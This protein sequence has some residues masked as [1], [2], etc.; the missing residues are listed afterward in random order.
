MT[1]FHGAPATSDEPFDHDGSARARSSTSAADSARQGSSRRRRSHRADRTSAAGRARS[2]RAAPQWP[3]GTA[4]AGRR[5]DPRS[6]RESEFGNQYLTGAM[7][8]LDLGA[9]ALPRVAASG[10]VRASPGASS[11]A[12]PAA[13]SPLRTASRGLAN[14]STG[15]AAIADLGDLAA[16]RTQLFAKTQLLLRRCDRHRDMMHGAQAVHGRSA[17]GCCATS[18]VFPAR[19]V[20]PE[21]DAGCPFRRRRCSRAVWGISATVFCASR[22]TRV[23]LWRPR[24]A[25][26]ASKSG[27]PRASVD[28]DR[29][30]SARR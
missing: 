16:Y 1:T 3:R 29:S 2:R 5:S 10:R 8:A 21:T 4:R 23:T 6:R 15:N 19:R 13:P 12:N 20:H 14:R 9:S 26:S 11:I 18:I 28:P 27:R 24:I 30:R 7:P 22:T 25:W 17:S